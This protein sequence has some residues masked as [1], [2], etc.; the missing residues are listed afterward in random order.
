MFLHVSTVQ[1]R[2]EARLGPLRTPLQ[3]M[4]Q[5]LET[6]AGQ[7]PDKTRAEEA[8][9]LRERLEE[10]GKRRGPQPLREIIPI[11]LARLGSKKVESTN[12]GT[13]LS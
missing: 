8:R 3:Q 10:L 1:E 2:D 7:L 5:D 6:V 12:E 9:P 13:G 11:V 4:R